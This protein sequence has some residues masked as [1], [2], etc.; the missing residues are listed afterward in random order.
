[1]KF[2]ITALFMAL[3][4]SSAQAKISNADASVLVGAAVALDRLAK[5][6]SLENV[7][8]GAIRSF[9]KPN[10][11]SDS[12]NEK[13]KEITKTT[14]RVI[15]QIGD[16][17]KYFNDSEVEDAIITGAIYSLLTY[18]ILRICKELRGR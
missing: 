8:K 14:Q 18:T 12:M 15:D 17:E 5:S 2:Y 10:S 3:C 4:A 9:T 13:I 7:I 6:P 11:T 1:M 16:K